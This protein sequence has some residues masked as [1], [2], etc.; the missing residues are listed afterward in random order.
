MTR[1]NAPV[2]STPIIYISGSAAVSKGVE[3]RTGANLDVQLKIICIQLS[4][5]THLTFGVEYLIT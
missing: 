3:N 4:A 2:T 5:R 1:R